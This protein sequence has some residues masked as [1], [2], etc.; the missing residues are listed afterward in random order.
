MLGFQDVTE[1]LPIL[2]VVVIPSRSEGLS[3]T[4]LE[5]MACR[6]PIVAF[7]TGALPELIFPCKTG[8]LVAKEQIRELAQAILFW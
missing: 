5:A 7:A 3:I 2:N 6:R 4:A 1:I 8:I